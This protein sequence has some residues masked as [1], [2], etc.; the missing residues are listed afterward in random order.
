MFKILYIFAAAL[1]FQAVLFSQWSVISSLPGA[2]VNDV[3]ISGN[4][5]YSGTY[6][7]VFRSTD[8][9]TSW[10]PVN[11]GLN[12]T[13]ALTV[14]QLLLTGGVLYAATVDGIYR[15]SNL[16]SNWIKKSDGIVVGGGASYTF[17]ESIFENAGVLYTGTYTGI[18]SST[19]SGDNWVVT[20]ISGSDI[21]AKNFLNYNGTIFAA[22]ESINIP[23]S[24]K[25][26]DN[27]FTWSPFSINSTYLPAITFFNDGARLYAGTIDGVWLS[28]NNGLNWVSR[29][30]GLSQDPYSTSIIRANG[31]LVTSLKFGGSGIFSSTNDGAIWNDF[32]TGLPFLNEI[33]KLMIFNNNILAATSGGLYKRNINDL[34]GITAVSS[35]IPSSFALRQ[36]YPNPFNPNTKI[37]FQ[38]AKSS[39][40]KIT[41][42]DALGREISALVNEQLNP[43]TYEINFDGSALSS[44]IYFYVLKAESFSE[45]RKMLIIK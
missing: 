33:S 22:R 16:G 41:V 34:N 5:L 14:Y 25:S 19:N 18:Y 17:A 44:G 45:T 9:A 27:G 35:E 11:S 38:V 29:N 13:Q 8:G 39:S 36:N 42:C 24:Y 40:V 32:G 20:N 26:T 1:M 10:Q 15:S 7:G 2:S 43:G 3:V 37:R 31:V 6:N 23:G 4:T 28:T 12:N 30:Q 21:D